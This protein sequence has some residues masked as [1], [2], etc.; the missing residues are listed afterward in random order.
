MS[1]GTGHEDGRHGKG[2]LWRRG[3]VWWIQ[4]YVHGQQHRESS[5]SD[6]KGV[7]EKLLMKRLVNAEDGTIPVKISITYDEMRQRLV[8]NRQLNDGVT[9][10]QS[11][12]CLKYLDQ[13]F[14]GKRIITDEDVDEF[15]V[16]RKA[17]GV[18]NA[19][20]N[21]SL[22][23]LRQMY[24]LSSKKV[25]NPPTVK[26]LPEPPPR[27]GFLTRDQYL[28][29]LAAL[30]GRVRPI[31]KFGYHTGM[32]F[33]ELHHLTWSHIDVT[34]EMIRLEAEDT[35]SGEGREIP[36][37]YFPELVELI[38]ELHKQSTSDKVFGSG[39]FR[40]AWSRACIRVGV[41]RMLWECKTC[42]R[43]IESDKQPQRPGKKMEKPCCECGAACH[44][45][46]VGLIFHDLRRTAIRNMIRAGVD[47]SVA[48]KISGHKTNYI[49]KRYNI[50]D[51]ADV[52]QGMK[53]LAEFYRAEDAK[54]E[55]AAARPN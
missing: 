20:I 44:W 50:V 48:M 32:R 27:K 1:K 51:T 43:R 19:T 14:L 11:T 30:P 24:R 29:L 23:A 12:A 13:F 53:K 41:G 10:K 25:K 52:K 36:I 42:H 8:T 22:A 2:R 45:K 49:F 47:E 35:K 5:Q 33:G 7:A 16:A 4:Y 46:Y 39:G 26:L 34:E 9:A 15:K 21:R 18:S 37:G 55:P 3:N 31:F 17:T 6:K 38:K 40:K 54:L 28:R